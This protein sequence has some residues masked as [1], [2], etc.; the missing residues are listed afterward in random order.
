[1]GFVSGRAARI[2]ADLIC[3]LEQ[4]ARRGWA[5]QQ[6][7]SVAPRIR[8]EETGH[9]GKRRVPLDPEAGPRKPARELL[10]LSTASSTSAGWAFAAGVNAS[11][12]PMWI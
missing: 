5:G 1:M 9:V 12:T 8:G 11:V 3:V 10:Q 2:G 7:D 6:L 4:V